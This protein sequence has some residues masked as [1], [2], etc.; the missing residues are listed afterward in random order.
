MYQLSLFTDKIHVT[1]DRL[2]VM[3][4]GVAFIVK[5]SVCSIGVALRPGLRRLGAAD[6]LRA[7]RDELVEDFDG[8]FRIT[9]A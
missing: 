2:H 8:R 7:R 6:A 5:L 4:E 1:S 9:Q 3:T